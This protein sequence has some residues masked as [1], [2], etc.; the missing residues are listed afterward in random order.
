MA[1][2]LGIWPS[3][4]QGWKNRNKIPIWRMS[5]ILSKAAEMNIDL[6]DID[7]GEE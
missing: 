4:V 7:D 5:V 6:A 2:A 3:V 1:K